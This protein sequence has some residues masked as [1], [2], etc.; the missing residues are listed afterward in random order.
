MGTDETGWVAADSDADVRA[1]VKGELLLLE[2]R[3]RADRDAVLDLL[4]EDFVEFGSSGRTRHRSDVVE[5]L[6][7]NPGDD[8]EARDIRA[9]HLGPGAVL[10]TYAVDV[11]GRGASVRSSVWRRD[12]QSW[13]LFF[14]QGTPTGTVTVGRLGDGE[15]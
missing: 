3:I 15:D 9:A 7:K 5:G 8:V 2:P 1:A 14:H 12:G 4:H 11:P 10:L 13:R 6:E